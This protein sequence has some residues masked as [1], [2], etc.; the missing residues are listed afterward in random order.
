MAKPYGFVKCTVSSKPRI[1]VSKHNH[2]R[3]YHLH[4][5]LAVPN[6]TGE[7]DKWDVAVNVGTDDS[8]DLLRYR[9][10][11]DFHHPLTS[12]LAAKPKGFQDLRGVHDTPA[13]DFLR[14][15]ILSETGPWRDSDVMDGEP[16][17]EPYRSLARLLE[18]ARTSNAEVYVFGRTYEGGDLG[19]HD[20]HMNQGSTGSF[21]NTGD[22]HNDHN[23]VWQDGAVMIDLGDDG[24]AA[25]FTAFTQQM[26]PTDELG[27]PLEGAHE[28][29]DDDPGSIHD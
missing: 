28:I 21:L 25:Y 12:T 27:N 22:D 17:R 18:K 16:D 2:E 20:V 3:Q 1:K 24:W 11:L 7:I 5:D 14:S 4:V 19:I 15:G 23:D 29:D 6:D 8:D 9:L 13:L 10:A 26:V